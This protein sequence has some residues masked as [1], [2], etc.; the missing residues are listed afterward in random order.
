MRVP[1]TILVLDLSYYQGTC[2]NKFEYMK[3]IALALFVLLS[4]T[5]Q[6]QVVINEYSAA[7]RDVWTD[8]YGDDPDY[9]VFATDSNGCSNSDSVSII[10]ENCEALVVH[11]LNEMEVSIYPNPN[12]GNFTI[13]LKNHLNEKI[14]ITFISSLGQIVNQQKF[15]SNIIN[16]NAPY[17]SSGIYSLIIKSKNQYLVKKIIIQ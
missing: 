9:S 1:A 7:N 17:L 14:D 13:E 8:N 2:N 3:K 11:N 10:I 4:F 15:N 12:N 16:F 6:L 5:A